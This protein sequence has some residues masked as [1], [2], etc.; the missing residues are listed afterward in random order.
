MR[1]GGGGLV[2]AL[3]V[4]AED[5]EEESPFGCEGGGAGGVGGV[6]VG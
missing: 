2:Q 3:Q 4:G 1:E 6:E 5:L